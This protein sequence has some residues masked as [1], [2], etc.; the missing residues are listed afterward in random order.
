MSV[1]ESLSFFVCLCLFKAYTLFAY[2]QL[3]FYRRHLT[4]KTSCRRVQS[5]FISIAIKYQNYL[6]FNCFTVQVWLSLHNWQLSMDT[7]LYLIGWKLQHYQLLPHNLQHYA[8]SALYKVTMQRELAGWS[9]SPVQLNS[10]RTNQPPR[11]SRTAGAQS[12]LS[13]YG[14]RCLKSRYYLMHTRRD[15][16]SLLLELWN[17]IKMYLWV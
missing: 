12:G 4:E 7:K 11:P 10:F 15:E 5:K 14:H 9:V 8:A 13:C 6:F 2:K 16:W 1:T 17:N 3:R